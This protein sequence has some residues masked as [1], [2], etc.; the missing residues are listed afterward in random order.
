ML[1]HERL[2]IA[3]ELCKAKPRVAEPDPLV[4][5]LAALVAMFGTATIIGDTDLESILDD[6]GIDAD[7]ARGRTSRDAMLVRVLDQRLENE[8]RHERTSGARRNRDC[9]RQPVL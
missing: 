7:T 1:Q 8:V 6:G 3:I 9:H 4:R 2:L 5:R